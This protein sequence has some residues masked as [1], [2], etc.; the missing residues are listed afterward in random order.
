MPGI[1]IRQDNSW[2]TTLL[3][4]EKNRKSYFVTASSKIKASLQGPAGETVQILA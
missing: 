4:G 1:S 3:V 2:I